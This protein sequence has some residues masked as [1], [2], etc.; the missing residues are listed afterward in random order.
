MTLKNANPRGL[1]LRATDGWSIS[2]GTPGR[3]N[4]LEKLLAALLSWRRR[5]KRPPDVP[6]YLRA[7]LGL[8]PLEEH[9]YGVVRPDL[10]LLAL[11]WLKR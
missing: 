10:L 8:P 11:V 6:D 7:D 5:P 9:E 4:A 2:E 3:R 1:A